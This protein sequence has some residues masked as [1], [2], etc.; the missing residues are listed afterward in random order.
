[1]QV[2]NVASERTNIHVPLV[3]IALFCGG[4]ESGP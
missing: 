1:M 2:S 3:Y 4:K